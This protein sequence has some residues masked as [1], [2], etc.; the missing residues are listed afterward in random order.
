MADALTEQRRLD[1]HLIRGIGWTAVSKWSAQA[2]S[3]S[4][5]LILARLLAPADFGLVGMALVFLGLASM[6]S[7]FGVGSAVVTMRDLPRD[8]IAQIHACS[9]LFGLCAWAVGLAAAMP[10]A[11]FFHSP[12]LGPLLMVMSL[13]LVPGGLRT[14]PGALLQRDMRFRVIAAAEAVQS[15]VQASA[16]VGMAWMGFGYWSLV[17]PAV[18]G[19]AAYT[20]LLLWKSPQALARP[21]WAA[22]KPA[23]VFGS[24]L[25]VSRISWYLFSN[26][27]FAVA[28]KTQGSA[29][30]GAYTMAWNL[31]SMPVDKISDVL[32]RVTPSV[33][34]AVKN[35]D[36]AARRYLLRIVE[37]LAFITF[38]AA[39]GIAVTA[40]DAV[41][42]LLGA[43]WTQSI[44]PLRLLAC[45]ASLRSI[46]TILPHVIV[47]RNDTR[48]AMWG[49]LFTLVVLP[50]AFLFAS[51]WGI[52]GIAWAWVVA[53]PVVTAPLYIRTFQLIH[54]RIGEY[55]SALAP[56]CAATAVMV[57]CAAAVRSAAVTWPAPARLA[58]AIAVGAAAYLGTYWFAFRGRLD[59][60]RKVIGLQSGA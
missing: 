44:T 18:A 11:W 26:A 6:V 14:V 21:R 15:V 22:L 2:V 54:L 17:W 19:S 37:P 33:F 28:G 30:L 25:L 60:Y 7:E 35:D 52:D 16:S 5:M 57:A 58:A 10:L 56:T 24:H 32:T 50:S 23:L 47:S 20:A 13:T 46:S 9:I 3:W 42:V 48:F 59:R 51:R 43:K 45:Y 4:A 41:P 55:L 40:P 8:V 31:A 27:D 39:F 53:Y 1:R 38:P 36:A 49:S 34:S 29:P 12:A